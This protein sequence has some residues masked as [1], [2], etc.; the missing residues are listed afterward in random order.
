MRPSAK[1]FAVPLFS[2]VRGEPHCPTFALAAIGATIGY[3]LIYVK[4][5]ATLNS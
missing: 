3:G 5:R 1:A 4:R 2:A